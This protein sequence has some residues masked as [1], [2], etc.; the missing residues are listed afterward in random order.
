MRNSE[1]LLKTAEK[2]KQMPDFNDRFWYVPGM[3]NEVVKWC[4]KLWC[5]KASLEWWNVPI[6]LWIKENALRINCLYHVENQCAIILDKCAQVYWWVQTL[7][8]VHNND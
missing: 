6:L 4:F 1:S 8:M 3:F 5:K 2:I 7:D